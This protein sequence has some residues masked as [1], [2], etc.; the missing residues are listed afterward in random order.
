MDY[1]SSFLNGFRTYIRSVVYGGTDGIITIFAVVAGVSGAALPSGVLLILGVA[2]LF[3]DALS[4][5][6]SDYLSST[7][8]AE[9]ELVERNAF[10][11]D[12]DSDTHL[13]HTDLMRIFRNKGFSK[14]EAETLTQIIAGNRELSIDLMVLDAENC[15]PPHRPLVSALYTFMSF[16]FFGFIPLAL[17]ILLL[18]SPA[19]TITT[20]SG[21][22]F[23]VKVTENRV[24]LEWTF[25][26]GTG[27]TLMTLFALGILKGRLTKS[28]VKS[29]WWNG[30]QMVSVGGA[31]AFVAYLI[32]YVLAALEGWAKSGAD[33]LVV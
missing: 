10:G 11:R 21:S 31:A 20:T 15:S 8:D 22:D 7:A 1:Y 23:S 19:P 25:Y 6:V 24:G 13:I 27:F 9:K 4:M 2:T 26:Y 14:A 28:T 18:P 33:P 16:V 32:A 29:N 17:Y 3:A 5:S 30:F 12:Y